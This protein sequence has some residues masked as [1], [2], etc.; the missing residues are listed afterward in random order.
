AAHDLAP[1][2]ARAARSPLRPAD[3]VRRRR[4]GERDH[5]REARLRGRLPPVDGGGASELLGND[6]RHH[7]ADVGPGALAGG[8][9]AG[10]LVEDLVVDHVTESELPLHRPIGE[11][12]LRAPDHLGR[13]RGFRSETPRHHGLVQRPT[14]QLRVLALLEPEKIEQLAARVTRVTTLGEPDKRH[15][16]SAAPYSPAGYQNLNDDSSR[17]VSVCEIPSI[18]RMRASARSKASRLSARSSATMARRPLV[19]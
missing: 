17:L 2:R 10:V 16:A 5:H 1:A 19:L 4:P 15:A 3:H 14:V 8:G 7:R 13:A 6:A 11:A 9:P 12:F 18:R